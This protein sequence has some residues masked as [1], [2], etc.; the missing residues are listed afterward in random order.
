MREKEGKLDGLR[1]TLYCRSQ[2]HRLFWDPEL[3]PKQPK[4]I[5][6]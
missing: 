1:W 6:H 5:S 2:D 4:V 3:G